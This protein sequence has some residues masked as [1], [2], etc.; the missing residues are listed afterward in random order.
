VRAFIRGFGLQG[1]A[2]PFVH[3]LA[4]R[5]KNAGRYQKRWMRPATAAAWLEADESFAWKRLPGPRWWAY[6][7]EEVIQGIGPELVYDHTRQR[8]QMGGMESRCPLVDIDLVEQVLRLPPELAFDPRWSRPLQRELTSGLVPDVVRL[9]RAKPNFNR[10]FHAGL[11]EADL[12]IIRELLGD[13]RAEVGAYVD[14]EEV[15]NALL[16][17]IPRDFLALAGWSVDV[18]RMLTLEC[19]LRAQK[20]AGF[21][22]RLRADGRLVA[23]DYEFVE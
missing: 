23:A 10:V 1:A 3:V 14:L 9:R 21:V 20:D 17:A 7:V 18:W 13:P 6:L 5:F 22:E 11:T 19:W 4:R 12:P 2:P 8:A 15:R 16:D